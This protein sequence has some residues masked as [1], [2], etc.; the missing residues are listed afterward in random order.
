MTSLSGCDM[1]LE[2]DAK[3]LTTSL[4]YLA[5]F[6]QKHPL[7][8]R[9]IEQFLSIL[10]IGSYVWRLLQAISKAG[11]DRFMIS[12]QPDALTFVEAIRTV[13]GPVPVLTPSPDVEIAVDIPEAEEV[14]FTLVTNKKYKSKNKVPSPLSRTSPDFKSK[15]SLVSRASPL[16]KAITTRLVTMTS[17]TIQAQMALSSIFLASKPKPK[18]KLFAQAVKA[19]VSQ[20]TPRFAPTSSHEDFLRLLQLKEVFSNLPQATIISMHQASLGGANASQ[21]SSS[22]PSVSRTLKMT[23][24]GPT[25]CQVLVPLDSAAAELIVTNTASV[26]QSCNKS[27]VEACSKLRVES[28]RKAWNR[29]SMSTNSVAS[30][31]ELEVIK[32]W[33]KKTA[34]LS[35]N[36]EVEPR[37][38]QSKLFL[39]ILDVPYWNSKSSLPITPVQIETALSNSPLFEGVSLASMPH[40]MKALLL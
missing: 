18:V 13:Y 30:A 14:A 39:K 8:S 15:T 31:A 20:Q 23:T 26:V 19:N 7:K 40:I 24:Q 1:Y 33:L 32:Q 22:R 36:T 5:C 37:L 11:W 27:F 34:R 2:A 17:K 29:V 9:P 16:S 35:E 3:M 28:V 4:R 10:R 12:P 6:I 38:P 25:R 21:G